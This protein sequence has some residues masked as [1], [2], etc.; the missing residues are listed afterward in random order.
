MHLGTADVRQ[1]VLELAAKFG[2]IELEEV[3]VKLVQIDRRLYPQC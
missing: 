3:R 2:E 1:E